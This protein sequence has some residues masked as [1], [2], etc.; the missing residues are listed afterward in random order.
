MA[1][2]GTGLAVFLA[3]LAG[4]GLVVFSKFSCPMDINIREL[5][6]LIMSKVKKSNI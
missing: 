5:G 1:L 2:A 6:H 3:A 4:T